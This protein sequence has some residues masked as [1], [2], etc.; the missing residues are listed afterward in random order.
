MGIIELSKVSVRRGRSQILDSWSISIDSGEVVCL[1]GD[2]GCGKS[3]VIETAA[4]LIPMEKGSSQISGQIIRDSEGR[5]GRT[6]FG[7]CLQ[8][9]CIMGDE[10]VGVRILDAAGCEFD[11]S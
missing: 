1:S 2:N 9:D 5:R 6:K 7:L 8:E 11:V 3:T 10:L 4:G